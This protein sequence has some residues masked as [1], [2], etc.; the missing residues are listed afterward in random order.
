MANKT[1][2]SCG[3]SLDIANAASLHSRL[4]RALQKASTIEL[5]ADSVSKVDTAGLQ[6]VVSLKKEIELLGGEIQWKKPSE[7]LLDCANSLGL[8][9]HLGLDVF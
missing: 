9:K 3:E 4:E 1:S 5:K 2:F 8:L 6:L 7:K